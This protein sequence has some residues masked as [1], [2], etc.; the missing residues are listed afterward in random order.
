MPVFQ[1]KALDSAGKAVQ[2]LK[3]AD[4]PKT[5]R[6]TLKRDGIFL[7]EVLGAQE[8]KE[9]AA[10]EV[11]VKR[12]FL[13]RVGATDLA[14]MTRQFA[15][16]VG[17]GIPLVE[18]LSALVEQVDH[19]KLKR[20][21]SSVKQRVNEGASLAD[22]LAA[23]PKV[24]TTL[25][26]NMVRAGESS[27]ALDVVLFRL[28]DFTESQARLRSKILG[29]LAYPAFMMVIGT[30][31]LGVL[32]A[33][34]IPKI[35]KI[36]DD[37]QVVLPWYTRAL[38]GFTHLVSNWWWAGILLAG[39][40]AWGFVRWRATEE[41]RRA[42]DRRVLTIPIFGRLIRIIAI[43]RFARTLSTLLKSGVPLLT[44]MDIV[45][46]IVG[47]SRLAEVIEQA[48]DAIREGE[49]IAAPLKRS[50]EFPPLVHHMVAVGE[51]SGSLEEMLANVAK[52]YEDQVETT[53]GALTSLLEPLMIV[54]MGGA[55][56]FIVLAVLMPILQLNTLT[57]G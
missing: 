32:F 24:F 53:I 16:L 29:T 36:F 6:A 52:A 9:Q 8:Q 26:V 17:A 37:S 38:I 3:E 4:S 48:R 20:I 18:S 28:A 12:V 22:A 11:S 14:I 44:A 5:L 21:L 43:G 27:G 55:V 13:G 57:G 51:R 33:V 42:W 35:V 50:G 41:G 46:N 2:G 39:L 31:I 56:S 54:L 40:G 1:Y 23:H 49:S 47:N 45:R 7:T 25:Y 19:E 30:G 34:V 15:V 10:R